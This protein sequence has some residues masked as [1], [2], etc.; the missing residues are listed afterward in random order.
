MNATPSNYQGKRV[1]AVIAGLLALFSWSY[2]LA[3]A[4][5]NVVLQAQKAR[6]AVE[7]AQWSKHIGNLENKLLREAAREVSRSAAQEAVRSAARFSGQE[8]T[9][10]SARPEGHHH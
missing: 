1:V 7:K 9:R 6:Q 8:S 4:G 10:H 3:A 5:E 2:P